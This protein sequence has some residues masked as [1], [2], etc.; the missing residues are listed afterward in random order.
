[1]RKRQSCLRLGVS[2]G[3]F[4]LT[5]A[6]V[7]G[8]LFSAFN[9]DD[10]L[11]GE[12]S[13]EARQLRSSMGSRAPGLQSGSSQ[14]RCGSAEGWAAYIQVG[15]GSVVR[16]SSCPGLGCQFWRDAKF[17]DPVRGQ[18]VWTGR[19]LALSVGVLAVFPWHGLLSVQEEER[20]AVATLLHIQPEPFQEPHQGWMAA[21][22]VCCAPVGPWLMSF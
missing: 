3:A 17:R 13:A 6:R 10:V 7:T 2:V 5:A 22:G 11:L 19:A 18:H 8:E 4:V 15:G 16:G 9:L 20:E 12:W 1:M 21:E 14:V